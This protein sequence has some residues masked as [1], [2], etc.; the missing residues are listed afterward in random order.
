MIAGRAGASVAVIPGEMMTIANNHSLPDKQ[1]APATISDASATAPLDKKWV[2]FTIGCGVAIICIP[3]AAVVGLIVWFL[4][5][6][7]FVQH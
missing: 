2:R 5:N 1:Q 7:F 4:A 6:Y 3:V